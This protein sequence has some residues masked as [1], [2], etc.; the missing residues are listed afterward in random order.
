MSPTYNPYL[1]VVSAFIAIFASYTALELAGHVT[2]TRSNLWLAGS[3]LVMG[4]GIWSMHFLAM[5][6]FSLPVTINYD[7]FLVAVSLIAAIL[8]SGQAFFIVSRSTIQLPTLLLGA[9]S[10]G[11]GIA[12]MHYIGMAAMRMAATTNY[13][14][15]LFSVSVLIAIVVSLVALGLFIKFG[16]S[17]GIKNKLL[18]AIIAIVMGVAVLSMH[19]TGMAAA[20][21]KPDFSILVE[22]SNSINNANITFLVF[23]VTFLILFFA[24]V[25]SG[26]K[27]ERN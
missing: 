22:T 1:V 12:G 8:A 17:G 11:I 16:R 9:V 6:A 18:Q 2:V 19:Y 21:F 4:T 27:T 25:I 20:R 5:L 3:A 7:F 23:G 15:T 26:D 14:P 24:L 13:D 10:M